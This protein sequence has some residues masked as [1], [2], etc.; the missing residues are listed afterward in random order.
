M[1][2]ATENLTAVLYKI[3]DL[4]LEKRSVPEPRDDEVLLEMGSVGICGS[5]VHYLVHGCIGHF[6]VKAPM[7]IGHEASGTVIKTGKKVKNLKPGDRVAIE[8][9]VPC[10]MCDFCKE[11]RYNLC[12]DVVFCAT[13]PWDGNLCQYYTHAADFCFKLPDHVSLEEGALLEPLSVGVHACRRANVVLGSTVLITGAGPIGLVTLLSAKAMGA[14]QVLITDL[15]PNR[16]E[17]AKK[18]GA[19]HTLQLNRDDDDKEIVKK[20]H[21]LLGKHPDKSVDCSGAELSVRIAI[22]ATKSGGTV[23][24]V[25]HGPADVSVPL[26]NACAREVDIRGLITHN[27]TLEETLEAFETAKTGAGEVLLDMGC[28]GICGSDV[29]YLVHGCIGQFVVKAPMVIGHEG[30]DVAFCAT[31]PCDGN[32]CQYYTHAADFCFKLPDDVSLEEGALLEP[33]SVGVHACRRANVVLGSTVLITGAGPI[34][35]V[36]L[37]SAKAM[38]A[39][40]IN[41]DDA[42]QDIVKKIHELLR[43]HPE[44]SVECSGAQMSVRIAVQATKSGGTVVLVGSGPVDVN[45]PMTSVRSREV[46][47]RGVFRY[48]NVY[49]A[50][51]KMLAS[52]KVNVKQLITHNFTLEE[53][54]SF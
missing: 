4:R 8:P 49:P 18:M 39:T 12:D 23:V 43:K 38:G 46:D 25:G 37:L 10:R 44:K 52:G 41:Q 40:Q 30:S 16:L 21:A 13:P 53:T 51:L 36:T 1:A 42:E 54:P 7:V 26:V 14:T 34:G 5:D 19:D 6:V 32:L 35:L 29:H 27:F 50:A 9:G 20:I 28:I 24:I 48:A 47:V 15:M 17:L 33:L 45:I 2:Q 11:G 22:Q 31:P 3:N